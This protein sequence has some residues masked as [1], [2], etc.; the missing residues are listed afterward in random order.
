MCA[1]YECL[2]K[3]FRAHLFLSA[4]SPP[5]QHIL[6]VYYALIEVIHHITFETDR[7]M[8]SVTIAVLQQYF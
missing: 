2:K 5:P 8:L 1:L 7:M 3:F 6:E 4:L